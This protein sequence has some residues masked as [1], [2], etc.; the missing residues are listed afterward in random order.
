MAMA[1]SLTE[2]DLEI[3]RRF[4]TC[5]VANAIDSFSVRLRNTG[6]ADA[7]VRCMFE[8]LQ[9]TVGYAVTARLSSGE[10]PI[11][12]GTFRERVDF[13]NS[14]LEI[15]PPRILV[16]QDMD[17][18]PGRGAFVGQ[19][20]A[21]ILR[22]LGCISYVT[23]GAVRELPSVREIGIQLF[24]GHVAVSRAYAHIFEIGQ[25]ITVGGMEVRQGD[26]LHG[27]RHGVLTIPMEIA[28]QLPAAADRLQ[29]AEQKVIDFC[30]SQDFSIPKLGDLLKTLR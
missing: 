28:S 6:F 23:N 7:R 27:N 17:D 16:L 25:P 11:V 13:W 8:D 22:A 2:H 5:M 29:K 9:P 21:A 12:G 20:N 10:P 18:P 24:A 4:D 14:I 1:P 19:M 30:R 26:L 15:P 3:L